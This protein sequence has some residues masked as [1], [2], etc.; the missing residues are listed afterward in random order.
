V[1]YVNSK[2]AW[3]Y[4][5][6]INAAGTQALVSKMGR[7]GGDLDTVSLIELTNGVVRHGMALAR[8][9]GLGWFL[10]LRPLLINGLSEKVFTTAGDWAAVRLRSAVGAEAAN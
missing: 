6:D 5:M 1:W 4:T 10:I 9:R 3:Y 8:L 7:G 2:G